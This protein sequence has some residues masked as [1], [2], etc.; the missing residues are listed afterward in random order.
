M[1]DGWTALMYASMNGYSWIIDYIIR[2]LDANVNV[3]D[4]NKKNA[5]HWAARFNNVK[6][7]EMLIK[8]NIK[9]N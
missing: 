3:I 4:R 7:V 9:Y 5:L 8:H 6:V 2:E 1:K